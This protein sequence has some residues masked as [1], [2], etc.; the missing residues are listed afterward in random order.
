MPSVST[1][2]L[3]FPE[4]MS[5]ATSGVLVDQGKTLITG[6]LNGTVARWG[7]GS[8][9]TPTTILRAASTVYAFAPSQAGLFIGSRAG[10]LHFLENV[11]SDSPLRIVSP[12]NTKQDRVWRLT[13]PDSN[14]VV[15]SSNY[16]VLN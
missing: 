5:P 4:G 16:G 1:R 15:V 7:L 13:S 9:S 2:I 12:T 11:S 8:S 3:S 14:R 6:H 10:D